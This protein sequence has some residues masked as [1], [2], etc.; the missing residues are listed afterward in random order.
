[1]RATAGLSLLRYL[2]FL[3]ELITTPFSWVSL[4]RM[5]TRNVLTCTGRIIFI[6]GLYSSNENVTFKKTQKKLKLGGPGG[7]GRGA[8]GRP[9]GAGGAGGGG[10]P[11]AAAAT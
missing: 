1:M 4:P 10:G 6:T 11:G 5:A 7:A 2:C 3:A 9:G 8:G